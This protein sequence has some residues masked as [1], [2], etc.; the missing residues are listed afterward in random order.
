MKD[1][2]G[3][4]PS[5]YETSVSNTLN[6][7]MKCEPFFGNKDGSATAKFLQYEA[8]MKKYGI[9]DTK[10]LDERLGIYQ[11]L[12]DHDYTAIDKPAYEAMM[13]D[14]ECLKRKSKVCDI[15]IK[16]AYDHF[17]WNDGKGIIR[18]PNKTIEV[19]ADDYDALR[20]EIL[21]YRINLN[22][23]KTK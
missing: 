4:E 18:L 2:K 1:S 22:K 14:I 20:K 9:K 11:A 8:I 23:E 10:D 3:H 7:E 13:E 21:E 5:D 16:F 6:K 17:E 19:E 12:A 15:L